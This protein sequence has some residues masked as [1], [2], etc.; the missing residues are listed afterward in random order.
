VDHCDRLVQN[1]HTAETGDASCSKDRSSNAFTHQSIIVFSLVVSIM[2]SLFLV[3]LTWQ[4]FDDKGPYELAQ[5]VRRDLDELYPEDSMLDLGDHI[6]FA[7]EVSVHI[8]GVLRD[9]HGVYILYIG[10]TLLERR[11]SRGAEMCY[12]RQANAC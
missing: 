11:P 7:N 9:F 12:W 1:G 10:Y 3:S 8:R 5:Q 4:I 6:R 2:L